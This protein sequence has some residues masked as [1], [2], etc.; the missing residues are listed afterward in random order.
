MCVKFN[1]MGSF[2]SRISSFSCFRI[3]AV[4]KKTYLCPDHQR[5]ANQQKLSTTLD[6][7]AINFSIA[8]TRKLVPFPNFTVHF[9]TV[10]AMSSNF[11]R[12]W[13]LSNRCHC[14]IFPFYSPQRQHEKKNN[15]SN[16]CEQKHG[17]WNSIYERH[18]FLSTIYTHVHTRYISPL[19]RGFTTLGHAIPETNLLQSMY[20]SPALSF[21]T[22]NLFSFFSV[23]FSGLLVLVV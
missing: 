11:C 5:N 8:I 13:T 19:F 6:I 10:E 22:Y 16:A 20:Y 9:G 18:F 21:Y 4:P 14:F 3:T 17:L 1:P 23:I 12:K 2:F 7:C 15:Y